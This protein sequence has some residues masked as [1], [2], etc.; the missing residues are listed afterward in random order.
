MNKKQLK[1]VAILW[2]VAA[3]FAFIAVV[4]SHLNHGDVNWTASA[5][6]FFCLIMGLTTMARLKQSPPDAGS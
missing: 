4:L 6:G 2:F 1:T 3:L 5:G